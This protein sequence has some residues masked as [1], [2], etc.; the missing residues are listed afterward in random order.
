MNKEI[1]K[2]KGGVTKLLSEVN[3]TPQILISLQSFPRENV[4]K[5]GIPHVRKSLHNNINE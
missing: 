2:K 3:D 1:E 5:E 4:K